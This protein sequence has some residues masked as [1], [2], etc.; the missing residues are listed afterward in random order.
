MEPLGLFDFYFAQ[1]WSI[2]VGIDL[3]D[4]IRYTLGTSIARGTRRS[5]LSVPQGGTVVRA[6]FLGICFELSFLDKY[7]ELWLEPSSA[8]SADKRVN[9]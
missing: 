3:E 2:H 6:N 7:C 9:E 5:M 8:L 4:T 1:M